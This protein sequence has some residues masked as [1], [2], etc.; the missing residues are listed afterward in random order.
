MPTCTHGGSSGITLH[1]GTGV[2]LESRSRNIGSWTVVEYRQLT[3]ALAPIGGTSHGTAGSHVGA[4]QGDYGMGGMR[5]V[6]SAG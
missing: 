1:S 5:G 4:K 2:S 3:A 6:L